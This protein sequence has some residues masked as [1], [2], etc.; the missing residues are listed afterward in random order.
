MS[1]NSLLLKPTICG[2]TFERREVDNSR[3][4]VALNPETSLT[5][6]KPVLLVLKY[7]QLAEL[8]GT[9]RGSRLKQEEVLVR[10]CCM[11]V[12]IGMK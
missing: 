3:V 5:G 11:C 10:I 4:S 1:R 9:R 7:V 8:V 2:T 6:K 12:D